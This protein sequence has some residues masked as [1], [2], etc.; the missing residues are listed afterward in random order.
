MQQRSRPFLQ[1]YQR[2]RYEAFARLAPEV[3]RLTSPEDV[4]I[5]PPKTARMMAFWTDRACYEP[6]EPF[7]RP[8][9]SRVYVILD[10]A[11]EDYTSW[12]RNSR[13]IPQENV[14]A[15]ANRSGNEPYIS[16][17]WTIW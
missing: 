16:L 8:Q 6:N 4:V 2:G 1:A 3:G 13:N 12:L 14:V 7:T 5:C 9:S 11:D 15:R 10:P 17:A